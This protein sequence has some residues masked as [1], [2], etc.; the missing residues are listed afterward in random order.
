MWFPILL[1]LALI[2][3]LAWC[4]PTPAHTSRDVEDGTAK[5][6]PKV[7]IFSMF[8]AE[9]DIWYNIP[10]FNLLARNISVPGF[11]PLF[12]QAHC[13]S[14][15]TICQA[16]FGEGEINAASTISSNI[17]SSQLDESNTPPAAFGA[18]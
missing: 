5:I 16:T 9:A 11:S 13:T 2:A 17:H 6:A 14:S 4:K 8:D 1:Q 7:F 10:E 3:P 15:G 18:E 12:P